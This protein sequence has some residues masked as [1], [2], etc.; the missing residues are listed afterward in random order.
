MLLRTNI[1]KRGEGEGSHLLE[2]LLT[3]VPQIFAPLHKV[4][5]MGRPDIVSH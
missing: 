5:N 4:E 2:G 3:G 1:R